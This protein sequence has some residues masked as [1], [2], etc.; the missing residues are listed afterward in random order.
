[1]PLNRRD[2]VS[3]TQAP[4]PSPLSFFAS[5]PEFRKDPLTGFFQSALKYGDVVRYRALWITHQLTSPAHIQ[6]VL[7]S[8]CSNYR[9]GRDYKIVKSSL[10]EGLLTSEG[11][12]WQRQ[13]KMAQPALHS[14]RVASFMRIME[15]HTRLMMERWEPLAATRQPVDLIPDL[16]HLTLNVASQALF[17]TNLEAETEILRE[18]LAVGRNYTVDRAWS[19]IRVPQSFPTS[20]NRRYR[21]ALAE[22]HGV[23]D[24]IIA[25]RRSA[26]DKGQDLLTLLMDARD[27][28]GRPMSDKQLRDEVATLLTAGHETTTL[29]LAW[30]CYLIATHPEVQNRLHSEY[31][32]L[33][34]RAPGYEDLSHL[35]YARMVID[36]TMRLYPPVWALSRSA[37]QEDSIGG[38][39]IPAASEI[40]IFPYITHRHPKWWP[41]P[42]R[43]L[44]ERFAPEKS[45]SR[46]KFSYLPF[47]AG[48]RACLG[49][50]FALTEIQVV[51]A[52]ILQRFRL[53]LATPGETVSADPSVTLR[54]LPGVRL[55]LTQN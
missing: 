52:M 32:F 35:R 10:G 53:Q 28:E 31:G 42:E 5:L 51:L 39:R 46:M 54:P 34:G 41:E 19:V 48:P 8:N 45:A 14:Q 37:I 27:D 21:K 36:E 25:T 7:Q 49:L 40:L 38:F 3:A 26:S 55:M 6:Y 13:R 2:S 18:A 33:S 22:F 23:I 44:P 15:E 30:A 1:V 16:M 50:N 4:G 11:P 29:A 20:R 43:F 9:K 17:T 12:L 47:G 24:R